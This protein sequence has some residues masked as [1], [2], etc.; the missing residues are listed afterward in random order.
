MKSTWS[1]DFSQLSEETETLITKEDIFIF[2]EIFYELQINEKFKETL[3][4]LKIVAD[5]KKPYVI[6]TIPSY[7]WEKNFKEFKAN[8]DL[9]AYK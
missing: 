1:S 6:L 5:N 2:Y 7:N 8:F 3:K 4:A 9:G